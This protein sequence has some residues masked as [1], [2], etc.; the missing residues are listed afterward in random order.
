MHTFSDYFDEKLHNEPYTDPSQ[1]LGDCMLMLDALLE[2]FIRDKGSRCKEADWHIRSALVSETELQDYFELPPG[3]R[4]RDRVSADAIVLINRCR[5]HISS[6]VKASKIMLPL[7]RLTTEL[8][9]EF[10]ELIT[11]LVALSVR[12]NLKY[13]RIYHFIQ[14]DYSMKFPTMGVIDALLN[15]L[16]PQDEAL[17]GRLLA[18]DGILGCFLLDRRGDESVKKYPPFLEPLLLSDTALN[19]LLS[20]PA[21]GTTALTERI[22]DDSVPVFFEG[23]LEELSADRP[24]NERAHFR[25]IESADTGDVVHVLLSLAGKLGQKLYILDLNVL[26]A[27]VNALHASLLYLRMEP[28]I[29]LVKDI[30]ASGEVLRETQR[31]LGGDDEGLNHMAM[32]GLLPLLYKALP[33]RIIYLCGE[34]KL[35]AYRVD[36]EYL[37]A[38]LSLPVPDV[39]ERIA[40]WQYGLA[41]E[42]IILEPGIDIMDIADC[43]ELG[44]DTILRL[45][46]QARETLDATGGLEL[47]RTQL[48]EL[49]FRQSTSHFENLA[50]AVDARYTWDDIFLGAAEKKRLQAACDRYRLR[51]RVG[52]E[53]GITRKNAYGNAVIILMYGPPG[54]GKT[55][56]AQAIANEVMTPLYRVDVSQIF[57]KYIGE[58]QKNLSRI[59]DEAEKRSVVLFFDEADALFTKRT[60]IKDSHDKY[61]NSDTS[62]LLQ[63]VEEYSGI[64]I[65]ATNSYQSFDTAFMRRL[66]YV[67]HFERPDETTREQM[68]RTMLPAQ[69]PMDEDV[70]YA[71]LAKQFTEMTGSNIKSV[72]LTAAYFAGAEKRSISMKDIILATRYEFEKLGRLIDSEEFGK[73]AM[74][75]QE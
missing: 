37:P 8:G 42:G 46:R 35:P 68:W 18:R 4:P 73:Y 5:D 17:T 49:L 23:F 7:D 30:R 39:R 57:S 63:K 31:I 67:V 66:T 2:A 51:N 52:A 34:K 75:I 70:D 41:K 71:F 48:Q 61:S 13:L 26:P 69:V 58:T 60:E 74:F 54:T 12:L 10:P 50:T 1:H 6:R 24:G 59:F 9:L 65:L 44:A 28:G 47:G 40:I 3:E 21:I 14:D 16:Y 32:T 19:L 64:S 11:V 20:I 33:G 55:M 22:P 62:F 36:R 29:L 27:G 25:Y 43:H 45:L 56:A 53:W 38:V 72:L 15:F